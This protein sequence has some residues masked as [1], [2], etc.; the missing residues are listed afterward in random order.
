VSCDALKG[1]ARIAAAPG[2]AAFGAQNLYSVYG[3][4]GVLWIMIRTVLVIVAIVK[5][6]SVKKSS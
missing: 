2:S 1:C 6:F 5:Q 3:F 4:Y